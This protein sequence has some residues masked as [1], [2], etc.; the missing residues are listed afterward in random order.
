LK[1]LSQKVHIIDEELEATV[2][3]RFYFVPDTQDGIMPL[4]SN[5][6]TG[7]FKNEKR[8]DWTNSDEVTTTYAMGF[9]R[10]PM[11]M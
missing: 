11:V 9:L 8:F 1:L 7:W 3:E 5:E 4:N 10:G 2:T 6:G